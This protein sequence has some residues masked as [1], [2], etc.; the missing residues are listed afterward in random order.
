MKKYLIMYLFLAL[1]ALL[2]ANTGTI[3]LQRG[4][5]TAEILSSDD[6]RLNVRFAIDAFNYSEVQSKEGVFTLLTAKDFGATT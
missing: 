5:S 3:R 1:S 4:V 6:Y 2:M